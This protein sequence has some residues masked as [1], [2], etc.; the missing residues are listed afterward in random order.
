MQYTYV[1]PEVYRTFDFPGAEE[2]GNMFQV[3][4]DFQDAYLGARDL[5]LDRT[6]D[7]GIKTFGDWLETCGDQLPPGS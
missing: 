2:L 4:R 5:D 3:K 6:S 1:P 7:P